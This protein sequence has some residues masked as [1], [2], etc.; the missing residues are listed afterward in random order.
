MDFV[1][2]NIQSIDEC[3]E[4]CLSSKYRCHSFDLGDPN[5]PNK[6]CRTSHLDKYSLAHIDDAYLQ[7]NG[8][9]TYE[10]H[11]CYNGMYQFHF[12]FFNF[13]SN[14]ISL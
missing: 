10:L 12:R 7:V 13:Q 8:A 5:N 2:Q 11:S 14:L 9:I 1:Y 6:V 4:R 3:R